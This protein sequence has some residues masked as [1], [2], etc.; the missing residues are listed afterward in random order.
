MKGAVV[1]LM[2]EKREA[3][4]NLKEILSIEGIDMGPVWSR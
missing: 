3:V 2:I 1:T 4:D